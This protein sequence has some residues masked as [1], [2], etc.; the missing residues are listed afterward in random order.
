MTGGV[1]SSLGKGLTAASLGRLLKQR[2]LKVVMFDATNFRTKNFFKMKQILKSN[3]SNNTLEILENLTYISYSDVTSKTDQNIDLRASIIKEQKELINNYDLVIIV[4][5]GI[6][7][8]PLSIN[9]ALLSKN[10]VLI[11]KAG[12]CSTKDIATIK[13]AINVANFNLASLIFISDR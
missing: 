4:I 7:C 8:D 1:A 6:E 3:N 11:A 2:G 5:E 9:E 10:L 13:R 12:L